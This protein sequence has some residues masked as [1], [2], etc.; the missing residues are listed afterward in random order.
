MYNQSL[1]KFLK[2]VTTIF[3]LLL[4]FGLGFGTASVTQKV[5]NNKATTAASSNQSSETGDATG[6]SSDDTVVLTSQEV[7][8]FLIAYYTRVD[9]GE[10][11]K[12]YKPFMTEGL[13]DSI[14]ELEESPL[15]QS[16]KGYIVDQVFDSAKIYVDATNLTAL[17]EVRYTSLILEEKD[18]R[19]G[20]S[21]PQDT[22]VTLRLSYI[23]TADGLRVNNIENVVLSDNSD[24]V[25]GTYSDIVP[26]SSTD[27]STTTSS[28]E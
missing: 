27:A 24:M 3:V 14:V 5:T 2:V 7:E 15:Q 8:D 10:N 17:V 13:Y 1:I 11:R 9:L 23:E 28:S 16:Y 19:E 12:R 18:N 22:T 6:S 20:S 21:Y 4:V 26:A 25:T